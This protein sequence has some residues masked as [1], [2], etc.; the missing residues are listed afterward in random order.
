MPRAASCSKIRSSG[1]WRQAAFV[2]GRLQGQQPPGPSMRPA[3]R[4][5]RPADG[6]K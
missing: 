3:L 4:D 6:E 5:L 2:A 1:W